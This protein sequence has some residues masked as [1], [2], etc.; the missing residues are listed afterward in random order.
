M[1]IKLPGYFY[2]GLEIALFKHT[3]LSL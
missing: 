2:L 3:K 1:K